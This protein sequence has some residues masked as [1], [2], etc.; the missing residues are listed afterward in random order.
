MHC[1][2]YYAGQ[3]IRYEGVIVIHRQSR[4]ESPSV[5]DAMACDKPRTVLQYDKHEDVVHRVQRL[6]VKNGRLQ[7]LSAFAPQLFPVK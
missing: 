3:E 1:I 5:V 6:Q 4:I 2:Q 7:I